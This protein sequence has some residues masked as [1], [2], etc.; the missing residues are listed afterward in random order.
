MIFFHIDA[1]CCQCGMH[2]SC[3]RQIF[4][5]LRLNDLLTSNY[6]LIMAK[7]GD[8][9]RF[10]NSVGGGRIVRI[11]GQMAYVDEDGFETPVLLRECVVVS[12]ADE[13][14]GVKV[15]TSDADMS[16]AEN[17]RHKSEA[18]VAPLPAETPEGELLNLV[19]AYEP[20]DIKRLSSTCF[21]VVLVN[22][23][24][25]YLYYT[26]LTRSDQAVGWITRAAGVVEPA[27]QVLLHELSAA[28]LPDMDRV[29]VQY[30]A[31][32]QGREFALK[33]PGAVE[34]R[35]DTTKFAKLHCFR[36]NMYFDGE[37]I[38][39]DLV[40]DD[41]P[42]RIMSVDARQ[43]K[44]AMKS[45][46]IVNASGRGNRSELRHPRVEADGPLVV[47]LHIDELVDTT[48]GLSNADMLQ[49]QIDEVRSVMDANRK[50][51]GMKIIFIHGKGEGVLRKA[52]LD[53]LRR[54]Y[55]RCAVQD[56]SFREY[57]F[58]A[59]QVTVH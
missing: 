58:G 30:V 51:S 32:K 35:L 27:T 46:A 40:R 24:N 5:H 43:L 53:E 6:N 55:P 10:L 38:A 25:Y 7:V 39:L 33:A 49:R 42:A 37:V 50:H 34:M 11:E 13:P 12:V 36:R 3:L 20:H 22:D 17:T 23:S 31:F 59:T 19:L 57:G 26:Y 21:D 54:R 41:R 14:R 29:C 45:K 47:D 18:D 52:V 4:V 16:V 9:V 8:Q 28:D 56:A 48:A 15:A 2:M 44:L 1:Y